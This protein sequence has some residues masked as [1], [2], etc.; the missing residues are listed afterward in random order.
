[1][2]DRAV[3]DPDHDP[4]AEPRRR[5]AD[6]KGAHGAARANRNGRRRAAPA[7]D[8][9]LLGS[10]SRGDASTR[11]LEQLRER[12]DDAAGRRLGLFALAGT[13]GVAAVIAFGV[14]A[15]GSEEPTP[16]DGLDPLAQLALTGADPKAPPSLAGPQG[17]PGTDALGAHAQDSLASARSPGKPPASVQL[18]RLSFPATL[19]G[20]QSAIEATVRAAEAEHAAITTRPR[21][22]ASDI[23]AA[24][25][26][27]SESDRLSRAAKHD[28]LMAQAFLRPRPE[29]R[30]LAPERGTVAP[31]GSE[32][33]FTLQVSSFDTRDAAEH[34]ATALRARGHRSFV[35]QA[36]LPGRGRSYRVRVGPFPTRRDA[37][38]YQAS[39]ERDERMHCVL[40]TSS[41]K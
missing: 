40:V 33:A 20:D 11:D 27:G 17:T 28:P 35:A 31:T 18:D 13:L 12:S 34:F 24:A 29:P 7:H 15:G 37:L 2:P 14:V 39:F 25:L 22:R 4:P 32:G 36:E 10:R 23:P 38:A 8:T 16:K 41:G 19:V 6:P 26:A 30:G 1:M 5:S 21:M 3:H 9:S